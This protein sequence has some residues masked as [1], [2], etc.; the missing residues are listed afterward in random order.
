MSQAIATSETESDWKPD[1]A[2]E[3]CPTQVNTPKK[4]TSIPGMVSKTTTSSYESIVEKLKA[5][6]MSFA[7]FAGGYRGTQGKAQ[8]IP[9]SGLI[10][11][12]FSVS[13]SVAT[14]G[15]VGL[16]MYMK[17]LALR[18]DDYELQYGITSFFI[19]HTKVR[20]LVTQENLVTNLS[21]E[22]NMYNYPTY[23]GLRL[24]KVFEDSRYDGIL[25][26]GLGANKISTSLFYER[27]L[28]AFS[29]PDFIFEGT[30]TVSFSANIGAGVKIKE[31]FGKF[32]LEC[33]Y[34]FFYLGQ[35]KLIS[36]NQLVT[37]PLITGYNYINAIMCNVEIG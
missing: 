23:L 15:I 12:Y 5:R 34:R 30:S 11:D 21:Y 36:V 7:F 2:E 25:D 26:L 24:T 27:A 14:G 13:D 31:A 37:T 10:G 29:L 20:G 19:S 4:S 9:I 32:P 35:G 22:Y 18:T 28:T 33:G 6:R 16:A 1:C 3:E 17:S 8:H